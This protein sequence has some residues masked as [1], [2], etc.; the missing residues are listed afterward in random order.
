MITTQ[1]NNKN[2]QASGPCSRSRYLSPSL[3]VLQYT[4]QT[5]WNSLS[6]TAESAARTS[7]LYSIYSLWTTQVLK[8]C[9]HAAPTPHTGT[10]PITVC[11]LCAHCVLYWPSLCT[12]LSERS[13]RTIDIHGYPVVFGCQNH[14]KMARIGGILG[15]FQVGNCGFHGQNRVKIFWQ[16][17]VVRGYSQMFHCILK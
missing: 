4:P 16:A 6:T 14:A 2:S 10:T 13:V 15:D 8:V 7:I 17:A 11:S 5:L 3:R 12:W 9:M 1:Y